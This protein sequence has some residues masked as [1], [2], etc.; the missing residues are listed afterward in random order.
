MTDN[1]QHQHFMVDLETMSSESGAAIVSIGAYAFDLNGD[2]WRG[3][4]PTLATRAD[5]RHRAAI[6]T[7]AQFHVN[8]SLA[9]AIM[10]GFKVS[11]DTVMWWLSQS[12]AARGSLV[13]PAP[14]GVAG[15]LNI[16]AAWVKA[17]Q[18]ANSKFIGAP[19]IWSHATFDV[20]ILQDA[21]K[22]MNVQIPW[23]YSDARDL[24]T[25][26]DLAYGY[27]RSGHNV[28]VSRVEP[29][30]GALADAVTQGLMVQACY[31]RID[32]GRE[33][34]DELRLGDLLEA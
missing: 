8:I 12:D 19:S 29:K 1:Q 23:R 10:S 4:A 7:D 24:R 18:V 13:E 34:T 5:S 28:P 9:S 31:A 20:P 11:G 14:V 15:G 2:E 17:L 22:R 27:G 30:H 32:E 16:F 6:V 33:T 3:E 21:F 26:Q 25:I